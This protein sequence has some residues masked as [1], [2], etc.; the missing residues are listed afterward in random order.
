MMLKKPRAKA[1]IPK[2]NYFTAETEQS[3]L[4]FNSEK[5]EEIRSKIFRDKIYF[6]LDKLVENLI[7]TYK[8]YNY[9]TTYEDLKL[10]TV[11]FLLEKLEKFTSGRGKAFSF[12]TKVAWHFLLASN[13]RVYEKNKKLA[14]LE[15]VDDSRNLV[16]EV[17]RE[18]ITDNLNIF[19]ELWSEW[20]IQNLDEIY[21][22]EKEK[23]IANAILEIFKTRNSLESFS[24]KYLYIL[25]REQTDYSTNDITPIINKM[26]KQ[27]YSMYK[28][29]NS[30]KLTFPT[31]NKR[32]KKRT[33]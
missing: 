26:K 31:F 6:A 13:T 33:I 12:C 7:H 27:F 20:C 22:T 4:D 18:E 24:K 21:K 5:D 19:I 23:K 14:P 11:S 2:K 10:D 3:I 15:I 29:F 1:K 30:G 8:F 32:D 16:N 9:D 17:L 25:I 28:E